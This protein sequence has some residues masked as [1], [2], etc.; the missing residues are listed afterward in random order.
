MQLRG[1]SIALRMQYS[2]DR[3]QCSSVECSIAYQGVAQLKRVTY[4]LLGFSVAQEGIAQLSK[5]Q[6]SSVGRSLAQQKDKPEFGPEGKQFVSGNSYFWGMNKKQRSCHGQ[7]AR[8][9]PFGTLISPIRRVRAAHG[10]ARA[11]KT[12]QC[13]NVHHRSEYPPHSIFSKFFSFKVP[14]HC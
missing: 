7:G 12:H 2:S 6:C 1:G 13:S 8:S 11:A 9:A 4:S 10:R 3:V 5:M 14:R